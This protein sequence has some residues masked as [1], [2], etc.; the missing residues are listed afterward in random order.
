MTR[1]PRLTTVV[2]AALFLT[3]AVAIDPP[4]PSQATTA[5]WVSIARW[6]MN[7]HR[8]PGC[9]YQRLV[10]SSGNGHH[11]VIG[12]QLRNDLSGRYHHFTK[13]ARTS[14]HGRKRIDYVPNEL[15]LDPGSAGFAVTVRF[16]WLRGNDM[17]LVQKGQGSPAGGMFKVK[18]SVPANGQPEGYLKCLFRGSLGDSQVESYDAPRSDDGQWHVL[19]CERLETG[20]TRMILDGAIVDTNYN[21]PGSISNDWPVTIGGNVKCGQYLC[22]YW[23]GDIGYVRTYYYEDAEG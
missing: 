5:G 15:G 7:E 17:N 16:R 2:A 21:D 13:A 1:K 4:T 18:T 23:H 19:R 9:C 11:G 20:G 22:N 14:F 8:H 10:D 6:E 3:L 12:K